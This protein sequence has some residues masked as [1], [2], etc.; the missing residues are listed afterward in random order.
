[1]NRITLNQRIDAAG[2]RL[3]SILQRAS[4]EAEPR[5]PVAEI[6]GEVPA[7]L[8]ELRTA[9]EEARRQDPDSVEELVRTLE[10]ERDILQTIMENTHAH[11]AY[12]DPQFNFVRVNSAYAQGSGYRKNELIGRNHFELFPHAENQAIFEQ[13]RETGRS[14]TFRARPFQFPGQPE[15]GITYPCKGKRSGTCQYE[16]MPDRPRLSAVDAVGS[17]TYWDW[18]LVPVKDGYGQ[19]QGLVLSLLDVTER[20]RTQK[21]LRRY[22]DRLRVLRQT[23]QAILAARSVEEIA[24]AALPYLRDLVSCRRASVALFDLEADEMRMLAVCAD[25][26]TRLSKGWSGPLERTQVTEAFGQGQIHMVEDVQALSPASPLLDA[27]QAEGVRAYASV[28]LI[29]RG[30]PIGSLN[31]GMDVPGD[32]TPEQIDIARE[33][34]D[35]LAIGIQQARL[36]EQVQRHAVELERLVARRTATLRVS[37]ARFRAIFEDA[38]IGI[39]TVD[40]EGRLMES[41]PALQ[42]MLGYGGAELRGMALAEF[43]HPHDAEVEANLDMYRELMAGERDHFRIETRFVRKDGQVIWGNLIVSPAR[44]AEGKS[45]FA[46]A[47]VEDVTDRKEAQAALIQSEMLAVTGRLAASLAHEINNPLQSVIGCLDLARESLIGGEEED[48]DQLLQIATEELERAAGIV[49]RMRDL[50]RRSNPEEREPTDV[51]ALLE[52]VLTLTKKQCEK[53]RVAVNWTPADNLPLLQLV[54]DR[55]QQVFLNLVLNA[56]DA[57]PDGGRL[58]VSTSRTGDPD[59]IRASFADTGRG[60][61]PDAVPHI[62]DAFYTTKPEGM[63]LGLYVTRNIVEEHGGHIDVETQ[64]GAGATFTIWLPAQ[65]GRG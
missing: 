3:K 43:I 2:K 22:A 63:G 55:V 34:A 26:E 29:V 35:Q 15:L 10:Q 9:A 30:K 42:R 37:E 60:I 57:M 8:E 21:A 12:L 32:L 58:E 46:I 41:N 47:M 56:V 13:V 1:M 31:L 6:L 14:V 53:Y 28:P 44:R 61:A 51:N 23:D 45:R 39:A 16:G 49:A 52:Q 54:P 5:G 25:G 24:E 27:L 64:P 50:N 59:G 18:G 40:R 17:G 4:A 65:T 19:V 11:L 33:M 38:D 62:F 36:C 20:E 48:A 7:V